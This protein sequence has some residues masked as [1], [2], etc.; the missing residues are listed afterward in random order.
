MKLQELDIIGV[1]LGAVRESLGEGV[2]TP[3]TER[4]IETKLRMRWGGQEVYV[5]KT[6][7]DLHARALAIRT[8][9]NMCNR[10]ELQEEYGLSRARFYKILKG[11]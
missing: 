10:R 8:R 5:K 4:L 2:F 7:V 1:M 3:D 11:G 6:D 9:Y